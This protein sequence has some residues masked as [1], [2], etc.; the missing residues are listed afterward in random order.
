MQDTE[1][2][3]FLKAIRSKRGYLLPH[4]G[5]MAIS[6][7]QLLNAYDE[8]YTTIALTERQLSRHDHEFVWMG[9][10]IARRAPDLF[11]TFLAAG[12]TAM[13]GITAI[14]HMAVTLALV[15]TTGLPLPFVSFGR[16][17]LLVSLFATGV[18]INIG[19]QGARAR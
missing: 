7:P 5:L 12:V 13:I 1:L 16:S 17:A 14:L 10:L 6:M 8:L 11:G 9:V 4:H 18:L 15:P 3:A 2:E 19:R